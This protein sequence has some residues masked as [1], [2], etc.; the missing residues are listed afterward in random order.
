MMKCRKNTE[1][2]NAKVAKT[3]KGRIMFSSKCALCDSKKNQSLS[4]NKK[5][6]GC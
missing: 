2:K 6:K 5:Q 4:N 3:N 1:T